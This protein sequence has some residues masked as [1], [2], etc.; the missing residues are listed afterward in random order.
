MTDG[1]TGA[2]NTED[3]PTVPNTSAWERSSASVLSAQV[4]RAT[5]QRLEK[6]SR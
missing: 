2:S 6:R 5:S 4:D 3:Q 1:I